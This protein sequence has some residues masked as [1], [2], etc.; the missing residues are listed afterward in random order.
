MLE[1]FF[2]HMDYIGIQSGREYESCDKR[3]LKF[4]DA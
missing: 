4:T 2:K 3:G 1:L